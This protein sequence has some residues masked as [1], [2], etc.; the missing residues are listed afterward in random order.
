MAESEGFSGD[1]A[2]IVLLQALGSTPE[3]VAQFAEGMP[4]EALQWEPS[5]GD[6]S[7]H[8]TLAHLYNSE[9]LLLARMECILAESNPFLRRFGPEEALPESDLPFEELL[10]AFKAGRKGLLDFLYTLRQEDWGREAQHESRGLTTLQ[11]QVQTIVNHDTSHLGQIHDVREQ[12]MKTHK[13]VK[14]VSND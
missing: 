10:A 8:M 2:H 7:I 14:E 1:T 5:G 9:R 11:K 6:W 13:L 4:E 3:R 12:W